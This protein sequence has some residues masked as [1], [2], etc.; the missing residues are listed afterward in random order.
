MPEKMAEVWRQLGMESDVHSAKLN[1]LM[2]PIE[3]GQAL[4]KP[5]MLFKRIET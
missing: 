3:S 5:K 2:V 1:E 4:G